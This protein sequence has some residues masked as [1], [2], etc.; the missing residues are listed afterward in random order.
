M[1]D[2]LNLSDRQG[3]DLPL[4]RFAPLAIASGH[5]EPREWCVLGG[6]LQQHGP[7]AACTNYSGRE[8]VGHVP[9]YN[10]HSTSLPAAG[11]E[12]S[13]NYT[14]YRPRASSIWYQ[15]VTRRTAG[16]RTG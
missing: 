12:Q 4:K 2:L 8:Y 10:R 16:A 14:F 7:D 9:P 6:S 5:E 13:V 11:R 1:C 15:P 3:W